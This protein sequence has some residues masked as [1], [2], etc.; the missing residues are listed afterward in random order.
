MTS[1][2]ELAQALGV[3]PDD[4]NQIEADWLR[5]M[6]QGVLVSLHVGRWRARASLSYD[7]LGL[8]APAPDER[9]AVERQI[10]LG[11]KY[12]LPKAWVDKFAAI[13]Q[14]ARNALDRN[15]YT[16]YWGAFVTAA[17]Y[18]SLEAELKRYQSEYYEARDTLIQE[19]NNVKFD[20]ADEY[21]ASARMSYRNLNI[22]G[23][24]ENEFVERYVS[25]ILDLV[26]PRQE[27]EQSFSFDW[28]LSYIPLPSILSDDLLAAEKSYQ[29]VQ[30]ERAR[31]EAERA[32]I[33]EASERESR[34]AAAIRDHAQEQK[35]KLVDGFMYDLVVQLNSLVADACED[36]LESIRRNERL[37]PR[38]IVQLKNLI[39]TIG[40]MNFFGQSD[41]DKMVAR[42]R[43]EIDLPNEDRELKNVRQIL[44]DISAVTRATLI[45]LGETT[46]S[47][48]SAAPITPVS[49]ESLR[50][51]RARLELDAPAPEVR[52]TPARR[53]Q[54][55]AI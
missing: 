52:P 41:I 43:L 25:R 26:P 17:S 12:L 2:E 47:G 55:K 1:R 22:E 34:I 33:R 15:A 37:H 38:S 31:G 46:R 24:D 20:L 40:Q 14:S 51:A 30:I 21:R 39:E 4:V 44:S 23:V 9:R 27:V 6:K 18:E 5:L 36:V 35:N 11:L 3:N 13:E 16:T 19:W 48:R 50:S 29:E 28:D 54:R 7:D 53:Q 45:G 10:T 49:A 32:R 8:R 42:V